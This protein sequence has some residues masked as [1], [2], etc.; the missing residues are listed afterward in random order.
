MPG[1]NFPV[2]YSA[3]MSRFSASPNTQLVDTE[4]L[5]Y[6]QP[7]QTLT[8][9]IP[10]WNAVDNLNANGV[11][12]AIATPIPLQSGVTVT[13][14]SYFTATTAGSVVTHHWTALYDTAGSLACWSGD[15]SAGA[16]TLQ[17]A[18]TLNTM[19]MLK[20][21]TTPAAGV[22]YGAV[23]HT[24]T[25]IP[26]LLGKAMLNTANTA[27]LAAITP[28]LGQTFVPLAGGSIASTTLLSAAA[29]ARF[30]WMM[31]T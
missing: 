2:G 4:F 20:P 22:Y 8:M 18:N 26:T 25:T 14:L 15:T 12:T 1:P 31:A 23:M 28:V 24:A 27:S 19:A 7:A 10:I 17:P 5:W 6:G 3:P 11:G 29:T 16:G 9:N 30:V 13:N 21:Y